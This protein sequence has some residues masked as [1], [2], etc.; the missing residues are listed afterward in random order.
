MN[1]IILSTLLTLFF[2]CSL[3]SCSN[4][5]YVNAIPSNSVALLS[6]DPTSLNESHSNAIMQYL[7]GNKDISKCGINLRNKI[8]AFESIDGNVGLCLSLKSSNEFSDFL[9]AL[10][11]TNKCGPIKSKAGC[12]TTDINEHWAIAFSSDAALIMGPVT[13]A[14]LNETQQQ[15]SRLLQQDEEH[16]I[17]STK[18]YER[19]DTMQHPISI[20]AKAKAL[21]DKI[22]APFTLCK[23]TG[24]Y[25]YS[26][27]YIAANIIVNNNTLVINGK[28]FSFDKEQDKTLCETSATYRKIE[29]KYI[30]VLSNNTI[31]GIFTNIDGKEFLPILQSNPTLQGL[32]A[33][34]NAAIDLDNIIKS[35][36]GDMALHIVGWDTE[37]PQISLCAQLHNPHWL[38][39][40]A[41]WKKSCP[42]G[43]KILDWK[44]NAYCYTNGKDTFY[45]GVSPDNQF[46]SG[47]TEQ[48]AEQ[49]LTTQE[50]ILPQEVQK[51][52]RNGKMVLVFNIEA[53]T[54]ANPKAS[55][56]IRP[57]LGDI[58]TVVYNME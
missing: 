22:V 49:C 57:I 30:P 51:I 36:D 3:V 13:P 56:L 17:K 20:I 26:K 2:M 10:N 6:L 39:D 18:M 14:S 32:L 7:F 38:S 34:I 55:S 29:G 54:K 44:K 43:S 24:A 45:F 37:M 50:S 52:I 41:Y 9:N 21:P 15:M 28:T 48:A 46:Y 8:Y 47:M 58:T 35:I 25:D 53:L 31:A 1:K 11:G 12:M 40:I 4:D 19:L 16:G 23:K 33:G 5:D 42:Q 27:I